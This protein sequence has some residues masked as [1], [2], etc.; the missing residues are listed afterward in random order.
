MSLT[1]W[2]DMQ[3]QGWPSQKAMMAGAGVSARTW[4]PLLLKH[5]PKQPAAAMVARVLVSD[6]DHDDQCDGIQ[7]SATVALWRLQGVPFPADRRGT[8][9]AGPWGE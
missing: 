3:P 1:R 7:V 2:R 9:N 4:S 6:K 8:L 5:G